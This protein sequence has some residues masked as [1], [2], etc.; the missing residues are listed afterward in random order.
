[1]ADSDLVRPDRFGVDIK[2][3]DFMSNIFRRLVVVCLKQG[4][5]AMGAAQDFTRGWVAHIFHMDV[6]AAPFKR[7][8]D[9]G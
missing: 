9:N 7:L 5:V 3:T 4:A 6:A 8:V 2:T 1:M